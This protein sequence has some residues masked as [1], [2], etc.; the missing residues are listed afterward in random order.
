[1]QVEPVELGVISFNLTGA[2]TRLNTRPVEHVVEIVADKIERLCE[3]EGVRRLHLVGHSKGGIVARRYVQHHGGDRRVKS[4]VTLGTPHHGT[5]TAFVG[6]AISGLGLVRTSAHDLVPG[7]R[8]MNA[9][10]RDV[11]PAHIPLTS[12]YSK[13]DLV[14]PYWASVLSPRDGE[15]SMRN[16]EVP[17]VGHS[18]LT[19]NPGVYKEVKHHLDEAARLWR[20]RQ[21]NAAK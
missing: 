12:I 4:V 19:W 6:V 9:L 13:S 20:E 3:R 11:F 2:V 1:V 8:V 17:G 14:C 7:S 15:S 18:E 21:G 16:V 5:P 10:A